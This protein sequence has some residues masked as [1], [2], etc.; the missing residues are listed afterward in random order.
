MRI[1]LVNCES[2]IHCARTIC[3]VYEGDTISTREL[4]KYLNLQYKGV[5]FTIYS[6]MREFMDAFNNEEIPY[7]SH[8]MSYLA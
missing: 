5:E 6:T 4:T 8:F 2:D 1:L 3:E 7:T